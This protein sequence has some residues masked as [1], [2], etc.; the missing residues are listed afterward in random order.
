MMG[1]VSIFTYVS[2]EPRARVMAAD[3]Y[4]A[5]RKPKF[6]RGC[7]EMQVFIIVLV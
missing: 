6:V 4:G 3:G 5:F 2:E 1:M 7:C